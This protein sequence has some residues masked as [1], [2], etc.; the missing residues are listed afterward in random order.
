MPDLFPFTREG[1]QTL[2][3]LSLAGAG[4]AT[5]GINLWAMS[6]AADAGQWSSFHSLAMTNGMSN[7]IIVTALAMFVSIRAIKISKNGFE[8]NGD[9]TKE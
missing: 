4:P 6:V 8:A 9:G 1:R 7:G 2:V 3:Y 5:S